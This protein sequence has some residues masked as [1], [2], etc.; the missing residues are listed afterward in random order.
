MM[1]GIKGFWVMLAY[2]C[3]LSSA[4]LCV[5][6]GAIMWRKGEKLEKGE[7]VKKWAKEEIEVEESMP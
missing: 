2:F 4:A 5:A 3:C 1:L 6:Y 7:R